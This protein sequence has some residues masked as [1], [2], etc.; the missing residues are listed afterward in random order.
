MFFSD[1]PII[2]AESR[3]PIY[4]VTIGLNRYQYHVIRKNGYPHSQ[5][6][7]CTCGG[8]TLIFDGETYHIKPEMAFFLPA[9]Y[10]HEY[11][12]N[13]D[14]WDTHWVTADGY[15]Y[16]SL[17]EEFGL[18]VP[19]IFKLHDIDILE[20]HFRKMHEAI[21]SDSIF[22]NYKASGILYDFL[23]EFYRIISGEREHTTPSAPLVRAIDYI[24]A[25]Y[26]DKITMEQLCHAA[27]VSKQHLCR[28]FRKSM[29]C[30]PT[31]Y[32]IRK[33]IQ[34][35]KAM[36]IDTDKSIEEIACE[37]GFCTSGYFC[38]LFK[39]YEEITPGEYKRGFIHDDKHTLHQRNVVV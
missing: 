38:K 34:A 8:G 10:P 2:G 9:N 7:Y 5:I 27:G 30:R 36:L 26:S 13:E 15:A 18:T 1:E 17:L 31:E 20:R 22:G 32:I 16:D 19:Q 29:N 6:I 24:N 39:R 35:A 11:F 3:L 14:I 28:L 37:I 21:A 23:I 33:R 12:T 25:H 4:L